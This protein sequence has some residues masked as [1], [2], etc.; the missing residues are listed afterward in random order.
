MG[1]NLKIRARH[2]IQPLIFTMKRQL[3]QSWVVFWKWH[4]TLRQFWKTPQ[5][6]TKPFSMLFIELTCVCV[7]EWHVCR[8]DLGESYKIVPTCISFT[9]VARIQ[10]S[11]DWKS[12]YFV[13]YKEPNQYQSLNCHNFDSEHSNFT[14]SRP[15]GTF[16]I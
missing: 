7:T 9:N 15:Y 8:V 6:R 12:N 5:N 13:A 2:S 14:K 1:S 16:S 3:K 11:N 4:H 10:I